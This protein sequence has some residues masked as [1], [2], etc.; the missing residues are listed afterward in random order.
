MTRDDSRRMRVS[1][2][3]ACAVYL[4]LTAAVLFALPSIREPDVSE[5]GVLAISFAQIGETAVPAAE[6]A[7]LEPEPQVEE[8]PPEP[9][10]VPEPEPEPE[11]EPLP[12]PEPE[13]E[14][15]P[16]PEPIPEPLPPPE[17]PKP[18][19]K[20]EPKKVFEKPKPK[21]EKKV[22]KKEHKKHHEAPK[23]ATVTAP[24]NVPAVAAPVAAVPTAPAIQT[25]VYG[26]TNDAFL[27]R[28]KSAVEANVKYPRKARAMRMQ[29]VAVVQFIVE[30]DGSLRELE[31]HK[32]SG[33]ELLDKVAMHAIEKARDDWGKPNRIVRLRFPIQFE[34]R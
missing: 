32:S 29:G 22:E 15:E 6:A 9:D 26:Q 21:P 31:L 14:P 19:P 5:P 1:F 8:A 11:Q 7:P 2:A 18:E 10:P 27:A 23:P 20:P 12:E 25:L 16:Q 24:A 3:A 4:P 13:P 30:K 34:L 17:P 33:H 28:V